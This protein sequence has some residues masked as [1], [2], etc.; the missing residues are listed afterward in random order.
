MSRLRKRAGKRI[1]E[2]FGK[3]GLTLAILALVFAMVGGAW[4]ATGL[5]SKQKKEVKKIAKS[6]QGTGPA[7]AAGA[8][9]PVGPAGA[10]GKDGANG[11]NGTDGAAGAKGATGATGTNGTNGATGPTGT[12]GLTGTTGPTGTTLPSGKTATGLYHVTGINTTRDRLA[13]S[14]P[15]RLLA[16]PAFH[17]IPQIAGVSQPTTECPGGWGNPTA[18]PGHLCV[19]EGVLINLNPPITEVNAGITADPTSGVV[20][21]FKPGD[22]TLESLAGGSW[23]VTAP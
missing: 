1:R 4:A 23:A 5:N 17:Y 14:F 12:T 21:I 20:L 11:T 22:K 7:G 3:A 16:E 18:L 2:P 19:Y 9:G 8:V 6:F 15:L 10:N 13:I